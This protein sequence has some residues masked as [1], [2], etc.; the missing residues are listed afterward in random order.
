MEINRQEL[1]DRFVRYAKVA[2]SA[3]PETDEY[4]SSPGQRELGAML[5]EELRAMGAADVKQDANALVF[6]TIPGTAEHA[7]QLPVIAFNSHVD[8]SPD[9]PGANVDPQVI[10]ELPGGRHCPAQRQHEGHSCI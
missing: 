1:L 4:P 8:T 10:D 3:N 5:A 9:A 7:A 6:A 2:T